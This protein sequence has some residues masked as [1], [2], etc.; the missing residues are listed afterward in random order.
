MYNAFADKKLP[1]DILTENSVEKVKKYVEESCAESSSKL[2]VK[3]CKKGD[4]VGLYYPKSSNHLKAAQGSEA[5][6][7]NTHVGYIRDVMEDGTPIISHNVHGTVY[8][9]PANEL[10]T[11]KNPSTC[12]ITWVARPNLNRI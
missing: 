5:G 1:A 6:T 9:Q 8:N 4:V 10:L 7:C 11:T 3:K 2:D 12:M